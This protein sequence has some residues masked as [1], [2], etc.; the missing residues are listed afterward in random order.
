M[1]A[2][3]LPCLN[4]NVRQGRAFH[5]LQKSVQAKESPNISKTNPLHV[6]CP[7]STERHPSSA[8]KQIVTWWS[9]PLPSPLPPS[10]FTRLLPNTQR[11]CRSFPSPW[12]VYS[13]NSEL[14]GSQYQALACRADPSTYIQQTPTTTPTQTLDGPHKTTACA[15]HAATR[16]QSSSTTPFNAGTG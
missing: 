1:R 14:H 3:G 15:R 6:P 13:K 5:T 10:L 4:N 8:T 7:I 2:A 9:P 11:T 16:N 12:A